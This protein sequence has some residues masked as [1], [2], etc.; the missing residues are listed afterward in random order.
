MK[1]LSILGSTGSIGTQALDVVSQRPEEF[2]VEALTCGSN[3]ERFREQL[4]IYA[5]KLAVTAKE[6][7]AIALQKEFP[8]IEFL[9]GM[10]GIITAAAET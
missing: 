3:I 2:S 5:P 9:H 10:D 6:A 4:K 1:K 7:D 8:Q